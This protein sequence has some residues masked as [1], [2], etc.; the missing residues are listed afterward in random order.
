MGA[1]GRSA[2]TRKQD[3]RGDLLPAYLVGVDGEVRLTSSWEGF[4]GCR[5]RLRRTGEAGSGGAVRVW[6]LTPRGSSTVRGGRGEQ[7]CRS[8]ALLSQLCRPQFGYAPV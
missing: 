4:F 7:P 2:A 8:A 3:R 1:A 5:A 6:A